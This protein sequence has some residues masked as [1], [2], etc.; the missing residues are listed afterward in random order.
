MLS[1]GTHTLEMDEPE[2]CAQELQELELALESEVASAAA[3]ELTWALGTAR[4][5]P[6]FSPPQQAA[7]ITHVAMLGWALVMKARKEKGDTT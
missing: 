4:R 5:S 6:D 3:L 1:T 2:T 7:V